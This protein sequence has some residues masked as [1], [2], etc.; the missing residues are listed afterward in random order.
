VNGSTWPSAWLPCTGA[1]VCEGERDRQLRDPRDDG[2]T[3][4]VHPVTG[5]AEASLNRALRLDP[6]LQRILAPLAGKTLALSVNPGPGLRFLIAIQCAGI[7]FLDPASQD[8]DVELTG[9][10]PALLGLLPGSPLAGSGEEISVRGDTAVLVE[11]KRA[12]AR[13][14]VDWREPIA[15]I[16]GDTLGHGLAQGLEQLAGA[17]SRTARS[18]WLD[19]AEYLGEESELVENRTA[20]SQFCAEVDQFRDDTARLEKRLQRLG[21]LLAARAVPGDPL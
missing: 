15:Q 9:S 3:L 21:S 20:V 19:T 17:F 4:M 18:L 10:V 6:E 13:L 5:F 14:R 11:L 2:Q 8:A 7:V 12:L 16:F 1:F